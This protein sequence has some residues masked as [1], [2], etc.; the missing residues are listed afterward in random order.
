MGWSK[1]FFSTLLEEAGLRWVGSLRVLDAQVLVGPPGRH[2]APLRAVQK[3]NL[4]QV[5]LAH[6]LGRG[7]TM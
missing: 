6:A 3:A 5:W 4:Q 1:G 7:R 2:P